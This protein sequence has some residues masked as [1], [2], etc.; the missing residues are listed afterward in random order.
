MV[1]KIFEKISKMKCFCLL[2][3]GASNF[4]SHTAMRKEYIK[5]IGNFGKARGKSTL[6]EFEMEIKQKRQ[7]GKVDPKKRNQKFHSLSVRARI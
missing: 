7:I 1:G 5:L 3:R 2:G 4:K 6:F